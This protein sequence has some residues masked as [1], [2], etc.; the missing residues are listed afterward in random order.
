MATLYHGIEHCEGGVKARGEGM[1][2]SLMSLLV[3]GRQM[4]LQLPSVIEEMFQRNV[5]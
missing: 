3:D 4:L 1:M 5:H 2:L